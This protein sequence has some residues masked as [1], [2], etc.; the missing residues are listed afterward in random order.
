IRREREKK[1]LWRAQTRNFFPVDRLYVQIPLLKGQ[2]GK[3]GT[4]DP[5][6][7]TEPGVIFSA[8]APLAR[9]VH[10]KRPVH[11][12]GISHFVRACRYSRTTRSQL[13]CARRINSTAS[14]AAPSPPRCSVM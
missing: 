1:L 8:L 2:I 5:R 3:V 6:F 12:I 10:S 14:R 4:A 13:P 7:A 11:R 9:Q